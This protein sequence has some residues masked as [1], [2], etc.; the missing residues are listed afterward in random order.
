MIRAIIF[1]LDGVLVDACDWHYYSLN[2]SLEKHAP[3]F[4]I[5]R[6][7]H[8]EK[9]NGKPTK[10]KLEML[11]EIGLNKNLHSK[12]WLDKQKNF[13]NIVS[14]L[15]LDCDKI[16]M[17]HKLI[18]S[19]YRVACCTNS[20]KETAEIQLNNIGVLDFFE[21]VLTNEDV[22]NPK[23]NSEIYTKAIECFDLP[24]KEVLI[25]EDSDVGYESAINSNAKVLRVMNSKEVT[26]EKIIAYIEEISN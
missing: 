9:Y 25:V 21:F 18:D 14:D 15:Q 11:S 7:E 10:I 13:K 24:P 3:S 2:K 26:Y 5:T 22:E 16:K 12:I 1:D 6:R 19:G 8:E 23:P 17:F 4:V 20:I